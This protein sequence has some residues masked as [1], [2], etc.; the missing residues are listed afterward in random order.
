MGGG[1]WSRVLGLL[2]EG[3]FVEGDGGFWGVGCCCDVMHISR[4]DMGSR[5]MS[6]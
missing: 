6:W 5:R 3:E 1:Y 4:L 2:D